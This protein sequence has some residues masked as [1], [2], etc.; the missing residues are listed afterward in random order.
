MTLCEA[1][2][3]EEVHPG[4]TGD[5]VMDQGDKAQDTAPSTLPIVPGNKWRISRLIPGDGRPAR[6]ARDQR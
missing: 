2:G 5:T 3:S 4:L 6:A 1:R